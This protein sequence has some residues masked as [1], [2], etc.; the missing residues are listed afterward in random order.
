M[1]GDPHDQSGRI[2][3]GFEGPSSKYFRGERMTCTFCGATRY[4]D[5]GVELGWRVVEVNGRPRYVCPAHLPPGGASREECAR[6]YREIL[7]RL[8]VGGALRRLRRG[9]R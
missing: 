8:G 5:P 9:R 4:S 7:K 6:A 1:S 2:E 3:V